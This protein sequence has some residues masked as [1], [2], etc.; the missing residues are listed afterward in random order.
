[1]NYRS[2]L[3]GPRLS[4]RYVVAADDT[5]S[6]SFSISQMGRSPTDRKAHAFTPV[7]ERHEN[8]SI[9]RASRWG[10]DTPELMAFAARVER[11]FLPKMLGMTVDFLPRN[12]TESLEAT[13]SFQVVFQHPGTY[14]LEMCR[15]HIGR[16]APRGAPILRHLV[17]LT[18]SNDLVEDGSHPELIETSRRL[19]FERLLDRLVAAM[20]ACVAEGMRMKALPELDWAFVDPALPRQRTA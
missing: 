18:L 4:V 12:P 8:G 16:R 14:E 17:V 11:A 10:G 6:S 15:L 9:T 20:N 7:L 19:P 2:G 13:L 5:V 1:M 3:V